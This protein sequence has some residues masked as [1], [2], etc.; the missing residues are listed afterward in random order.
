[1]EHNQI[2]LKRPSSN[3]QIFQIVLVFSY[4]FLV[5]KIVSHLLR[6]LEDLLSPPPHFWNHCTMTKVLHLL[7]KKHM[8]WAHKN[9][10]VSLIA[11]AS[12]QELVNW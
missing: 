5:N 2:L 9:E 4:L 6:P 12:Q 8:K 10:V 11:H 3:T 7:S 1:M